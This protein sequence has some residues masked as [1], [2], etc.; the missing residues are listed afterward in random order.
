MV[1]R[2]HTLA[3]SDLFA[4]CPLYILALSPKVLTLPSMTMFLATQLWRRQTEAP[5]LFFGGSLNLAAV[6]PSSQ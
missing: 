6:V 5:L 1:K 2:A 4:Q 3:W